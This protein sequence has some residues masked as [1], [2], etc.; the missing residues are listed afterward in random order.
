MEMNIESIVEK[1]VVIELGQ[2]DLTGIVESEVRK[3]IVSCVSKGTLS[4]VNDIAKNMITEEI[5]KCLEDK[6]TTDDGWGKRETYDSFQA[7]FSKTFKRKMDESYEVKKEIEKQV[8]ARVQSLINQ[9]YTRIIAKIV[10]GISGTV[11]V[12]KS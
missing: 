11:L 5:K 6:I 10:D 2:M 8:S 3:F 1:Q 9:E 12:K 4:S 7:L